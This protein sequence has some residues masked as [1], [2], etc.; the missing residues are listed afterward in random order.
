MQVDKIHCRL[1]WSFHGDGWSKH[2]V[3]PT[4][5]LLLPL[6]TPSFTSCSLKGA[7]QGSKGPVLKRC[8]GRLCH[9]LLRAEWGKVLVYCVASD[10]FWVSHSFIPAPQTCYFFPHLIVINELN[11]ESNN[12]LN[13]ED[14][15]CCYNMPYVAHQRTA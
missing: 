7:P 9:P 14:F 1:D 6:P 4:Q 5:C 2:R 11:E 12:L 13:C 15:V 8:G 3:C 10:H